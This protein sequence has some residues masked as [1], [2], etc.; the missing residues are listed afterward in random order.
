MSG[1]LL[2]QETERSGLQIMPR[3]NTSG[4][5][6][7]VTGPVGWDWSLPFALERKD[8]TFRVAAGWD[9]GAYAPAAPAAGVAYYVKRVGGSNA[10]SGLD[11]E[12]ALRDISRGGAEGR[13]GGDPHRRGAV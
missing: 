9:I 3:A 12:H 8:R 1:S 6:V 7:A 2:G 13:R 11:W 10:N 4:V 5:W